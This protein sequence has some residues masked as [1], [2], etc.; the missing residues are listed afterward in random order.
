MVE[1][2]PDTRR[3]P[4]TGK[5][6]CLDLFV[7]SRELRPFIFSL[8][9]DKEK[10]FTPYRAVKEKKKIRLIYSDHFASILTF[11]NLPRRQEQKRR[12]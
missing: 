2:G 3:D 1:G 4:A 8:V 9:I 5:M 6:S 12:N 10:K 11:K 7:I